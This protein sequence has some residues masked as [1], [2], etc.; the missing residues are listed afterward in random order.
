[1]SR[2]FSLIECLVTITILAIVSHWAWLQSSGGRQHAQLRAATSAIQLARSHAVTSGENTRLNTD[3]SIPS[4]KTSERVDLLWRGFGPGYLSFDR[5]GGATN[6]TLW[7]CPPGIVHG[8]GL[9]VSRTGRVRPT[10]DL[11]GDGVFESATGQA[12]SCP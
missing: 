10:P 12:F 7:S 4:I 1:M 2:G 8:R 11:N 3:L 5:L 9:I 6:G